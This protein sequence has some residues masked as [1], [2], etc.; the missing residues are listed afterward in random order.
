MTRSLSRAQK[1][2]IRE[3]IFEDLIDGNTSAA[4]EVLKTAA[5]GDPTD[6]FAREQGYFMLKCI[7]S[8]TGRP[9][10]KEIAKGKVTHSTVIRIDPV[11][12]Y[13]KDTIKKL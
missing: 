11:D 12:D 6:I 5:F 9:P 13:E 7:D 3:Q 10:R 4:A 8:L 2:L 1:D